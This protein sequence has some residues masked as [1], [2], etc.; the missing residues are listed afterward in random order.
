MS[1]F[2]QLYDLLFFMIVVNIWGTF[3]RNNY[4]VIN[5]EYVTRL[6]DVIKDEYTKNFHIYTTN[7]E[8]IVPNMFIM[9]LFYLKSGLYSD[10]SCIFSIFLF[11][12]RLTV[13]YRFPVRYCKFRKI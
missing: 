5:L 13:R 11:F 8:K 4:D 1:L 9:S 6:S 3:V 2:L 7:D 10:R 12:G